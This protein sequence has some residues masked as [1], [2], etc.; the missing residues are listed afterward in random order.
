MVGRLLRALDALLDRQAE[1][2]GPDHLRLP[3][4]TEYVRIDREKAFNPATMPTD[5]V[6]GGETAIEERKRVAFELLDDDTFG[7]LCIILKPGRTPARLSAQVRPEWRGYVG[8]VLSRIIREYA[9][10]RHLAR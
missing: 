1:R 9:R 7:F 8:A 5:N 4:G 10:E 3:D 6:Y 2:A